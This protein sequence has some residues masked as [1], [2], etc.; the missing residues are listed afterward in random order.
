MPAEAIPF[1]CD[2]YLR[3]WVYKDSASVGMSVP[4]QG[5][6]QPLFSRQIL[7]ARAGPGEY[8]TDACF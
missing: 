5:A 6:A 4:W 8:M 3:I 7:S 1:S 2:W